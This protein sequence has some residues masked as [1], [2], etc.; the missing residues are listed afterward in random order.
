MKYLVVGV[1]A[2]S[3]LSACGGSGGGSNNSTGLSEL[4]SF[5]EDGSADGTYS[6]SGMGVSTRYVTN[7]DGTVTSVETPVSDR[8]IDASLTFEDGEIEAI[9]VETP[10]GTLTFS[11][12]A[13]DTFTVQQGAI[14]A[15]SADGDRIMVTADP[16][17][18]GYE[19]QSYGTWQTGLTG[20]TRL[21]GAGSIGARTS[22]SQMPSSGSA[23]YYGDSTG[24][25]FTDGE[26]AVTTSYIAVDTDFDTV[27]VYSSETVTADPITGVITGSRSDL[28]FYA[29]GSVSGTG[30]AAT[31]DT[32]TLTGT[33]DGQFY[34]PDAAEVGGT[35]SGTTADSTYIGAFGAIQ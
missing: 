35:F 25:V 9:S 4:V 33:V 34:G 20:T 17:Q 11:R 27:E 2:V 16:L 30:F 7:A 12:S 15:V 24:Q 6:A 8:N 18:Q 23:S 5:V 19:Y 29:E 13:G 32:G 28:D 14:T 26:V 31:M 1:A 22:A 21:A 10:D 3:L